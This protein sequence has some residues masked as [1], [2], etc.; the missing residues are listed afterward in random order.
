MFLQGLGRRKAVGEMR[1]K[2]TRVKKTGEDGEVG[3]LAKDLFPETLV[4]G[5]W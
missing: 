3:R 4:L 1:V 5:R 2:K